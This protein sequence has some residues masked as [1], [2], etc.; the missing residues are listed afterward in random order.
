MSRLLLVVCV[1]AVGALIVFTTDAQPQPPAGRAVMR[2]LIVERFGSGWLGR[3]MVCI[4]D[5]E[6]GLDP[7]AVNWRDPHV[8]GRGSFGLFQIGRV[9]VH[10]VGGDWRRLLVPTV[11][12]R[13]AWQLYRAGRR[14]GESGLGPWGG[15]C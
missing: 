7:R 11:N 8:N 15:G 13:V 6:S 5:R 14:R 12:V 2:G 1:L 4:A 3:E 10:Y 9:H